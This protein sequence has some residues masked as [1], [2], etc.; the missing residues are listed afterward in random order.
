M[1]AEDPAAYQNMSTDQLVDMIEQEMAALGSGNEVPEPPGALPEDVA[2]EADAENALGEM[3]DPVASDDDV[4]AT[5]DM[6]MSSGV[7]NAGQLLDQLRA[8]GFE[9]VRAGGMDQG[10]P[11]EDMEPEPELSMQDA[12][13]AAAERAVGGV[14]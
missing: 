4:E 13:K 9:I 3:E 2:M 5:I 10:I 14:A 7:S 8:A 1:P 6:I 12:R 11:E